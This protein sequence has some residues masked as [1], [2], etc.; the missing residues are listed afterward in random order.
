MPYKPPPVSFIQFLASGVG[1][2][3]AIA[4][5][6]VFLIV[7]PVM[8]PFEKPRTLSPE[9]VIGY[10][11]GFLEGTDGPWDWDNFTTQPVANPRLDDIREGGCA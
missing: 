6:P 10:L 11:R 7:K 8:V 2:I 3:A 5:L 9:E 4:I 1:C